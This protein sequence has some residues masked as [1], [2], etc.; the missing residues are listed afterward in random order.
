MA[1]CTPKCSSHKGRS[2]QNKRFI[3]NAFCD[4]LL[5]S[6]VIS[7]MSKQSAP[8]W[9]Q[10]GSRMAP[11]APPGARGARNATWKPYFALPGAAKIAS[12]GLRERKNNFVGAFR[13]ALGRVVDRFYPPGGSLGG[14]RRVSGGHFGSFFAV[15]PAGLQKARKM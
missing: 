5:R 4:D 13:G 12:G 15:G 10:N 11:G 14:S 1:K 2:R 6:Y 7:H 3:C 8:K 9:H